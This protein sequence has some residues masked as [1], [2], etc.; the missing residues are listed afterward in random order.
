MSFINVF[1]STPSRISIKDNRLCVTNDGGENA[2][3]LSDIDTVMIEDMRSTVSAYALSALA[4]S[5][6]AV[7]VCDE[8]HLPTAI[9][10][11]IHSYC[12]PLAM[13][14]LQLDV[15]KPLKKQL[16]QS[17]VKRKIEGQAKALRLLNIE[18]FE[19]LE[20]MAKSVAS[21]DALNTEATAAAFYFK[22][23][24]GG[25]SR[26]DDSVFF[27]TCINYGYSIV[28]GLAARS[29]A[30]CGFET[31]LGLH[32]CN[33]LNAFNLADDIMEVF[34]PIVDVWVYTYVGG[35]ELTADVKKSIFSLINAET[36]VDGGRYTLSNAMDMLA[37]SLKRSFASKSNVLLLPSFEEAIPH[38]YV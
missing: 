1:V 2:F 29:L 5:R 10:L 11:P 38:K 13:L 15:A 20:N 26:R 28:R 30:V 12:R 18:G 4:A 36:V 17:I 31:S 23:L 9:C 34:R 3:P 24:L 32:H 19:E 35:T 33:T 37:Q 14:E 7:F 25:A 6:V 21:D 27:N 8:K 22:R 16:W